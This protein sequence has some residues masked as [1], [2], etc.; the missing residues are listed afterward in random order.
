MIPNNKEAWRKRYLADFVDYTPGENSTTPHYWSLSKLA[1]D[2]Q[3]NLD[4]Q[5]FIIKLFLENV[6]RHFSSH[7]NIVDTIDNLK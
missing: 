7:E 1:E 4:D 5:P 6:M 2:F 3:F